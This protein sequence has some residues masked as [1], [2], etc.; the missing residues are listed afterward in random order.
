MLLQKMQAPESE[1]PQ[2]ELVLVPAELRI[3]DSTCPPVGRG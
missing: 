3:R 1:P 2:P